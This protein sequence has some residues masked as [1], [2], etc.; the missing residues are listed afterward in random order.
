[1]VRHANAGV[2]KVHNSSESLLIK[3]RPFPYLG[4]LLHWKLLRPVQV[5]ATYFCV[6]LLHKIYCVQGHL[7]R[8]RSD[9]KVSFS[10]CLRY[11]E[12][13]ANFIF[14]CCRMHWPPLVWL[15]SKLNKIGIVWVALVVLFS[16]VDSVTIAWKQTNLVFLPTLIPHGRNCKVHVWIGSIPFY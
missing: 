1:M 5:L 7:P 2:Y 11:M 10:V 3:F 13:N 16:F 14:S 12:E 15:F 4:H 6:V 9:L 8:Q